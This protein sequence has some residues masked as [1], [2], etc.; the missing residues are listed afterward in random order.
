MRADFS[1]DAQPTGG[2]DTV[3]GVYRL[4]PGEWPQRPAFRTAAGADARVGS[5][6]AGGE[7]QVFTL[8]C[9]GLS[10]FYAEIIDWGGRP[11]LLM[12]IPYTIRRVDA[13]AAAD[14]LGHFLMRV[15][16]A[17]FALA[18]VPGPRAAEVIGP[19]LVYRRTRRCT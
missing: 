3:L 1:F 2:Y 13:T 5:P 18:E 8:W 7:W 17:R 9:H 19:E 4:P 15:F 14:I 16:G 10:Q 12:H 6:V 11:E